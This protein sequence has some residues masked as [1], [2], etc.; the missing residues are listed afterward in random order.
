M[1][2][3]DI[4]AIWQKLTANGATMLS[5]TVDLGVVKLDLLAF[6]HPEN[7]GTNRPVLTIKRKQGHRK[8]RP[9]TQQVNTNPAPQETIKTK[10]IPF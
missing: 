1:D 9:D 5:G 7:A 2:N 10:D 4:G 8:D 3:D 6:Y